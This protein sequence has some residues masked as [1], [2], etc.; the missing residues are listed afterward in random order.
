MLSVIILSNIM[1]ID[2]MLIGI[3][4]VYLVHVSCHDDASARRTNPGVKF[5][6]L[7]GP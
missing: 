1:L 4:L 2:V 5:T 7:F 6:K 3:V